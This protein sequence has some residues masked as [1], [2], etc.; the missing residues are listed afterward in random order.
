MT[1]QEIRTLTIDLCSRAL[2]RLRDWACIL[3]PARPAERPCPVG[4]R[5]KPPPRAVRPGTFKQ[6]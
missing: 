6:I 4:Y 3:F 2:A 1:P 5:E